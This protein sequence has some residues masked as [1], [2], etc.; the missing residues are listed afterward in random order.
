[1]RSTRA[2]TLN[3]KSSLRALGVHAMKPCSYYDQLVSVAE[4]L[5]LTPTQIPINFKWR[6]AF[7]KGSFFGGKSSLSLACVSHSICRH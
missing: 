7:D 6:D 3:V 5:P 2:L 4:K 1:M